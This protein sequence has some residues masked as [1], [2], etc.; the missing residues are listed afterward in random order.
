[1]AFQPEVGQ[2]LTIDEVSFRVAEHP[3]PR[4]MPH[5]QE[6]SQATVYQLV[7]RQEGLA[8]CGISGPNV[9]LPALANPA[10]PVASS[11]VALVDVEQMYAPDLRQ[12]EMLTA[13]SPGYAH[14]TAAEGVWSQHADRFAG[15]LLLAE[16]LCWCDAHIRQDAWGESYFEPDEM[17]REGE[18]HRLM[19][20]VL[21]ERWG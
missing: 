9:M 12:P 16:M 10:P 21:N 11:P 8:H 5:G 15:A 4:G 6:G 14:Q 13:G 19:L 7:A 17:Q 3:A 20:A 1:M 18:R 2:E